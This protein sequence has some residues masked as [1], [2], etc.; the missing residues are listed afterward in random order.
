MK[1]K[2]Y[3]GFV[4][5]IVQIV[6]ESKENLTSMITFCYDL[7]VELTVCCIAKKKTVDKVLET[8]VCASSNI[9]D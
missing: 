2:S 7:L 9:C 8:Q 6:I 4:L 3:L 1:P 5:N